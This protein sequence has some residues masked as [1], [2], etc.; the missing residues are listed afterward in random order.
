MSDD[1]LK[2]YGQYISPDGNTTFEIIDTLG[3][4]HPYCV[5]PKHVAYASDHCSGILSKDAIRAA[6]KEGAACDICRKKGEGILTVDEH[7]T[8]LLVGVYDKDNR[9]LNDMPELQEWLKPL[10]AVAEKDGFVGFAFKKA[11]APATKV[12]DVVAPPEQKE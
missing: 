5:T 4:P 10:C 11:T 9:E 3:V 1:K 6:E 12:V 8:A 7:G 2:K